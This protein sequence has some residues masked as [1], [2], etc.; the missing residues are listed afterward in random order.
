MRIYGR[1]VFLD[2]FH[3]LI[4]I[5]MMTN[6][7]TDSIRIRTWEK[8]RFQDPY[9]FLTRLR[10]FE[11][12]IAQPDIQYSTKALRTNK[13]RQHRERREA[14]LLCVGIS[15]S[16]GLRGMEFTTFEDAD[17]DAVFRLPVQSGIKYWPVQ[18]KEIV[19]KKKEVNPKAEFN[20]EIKK[21]EKYSDSQDLIVGIHF[22]QAT[23][24]KITNWSVPPLKLGAL[25][26][27]GSCSPDQRRWCIIGDFLK[28]N[29]SI[30]EFPYPEPILDEKG[31]PITIAQFK[32]M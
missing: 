14:A 18:L 11:Y 23:D 19:P 10:A 7:C 12:K 1:G 15:E 26:V 9:Q 8:L 2:G 29:T 27:F 17:Y 22:N 30:V 13:L 4:D 24:G 5:G 25:W 6:H 21:L 3:L 28:Q 32:A 16:K 20:D 31:N